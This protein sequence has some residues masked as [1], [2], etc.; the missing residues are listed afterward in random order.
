MKNQKAERQ[1]PNFTKRL[2]RNAD[3]HK[4]ILNKIISGCKPSC[5]EQ[6]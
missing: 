6:S 5:C 4:P 3:L 2:C 1:K